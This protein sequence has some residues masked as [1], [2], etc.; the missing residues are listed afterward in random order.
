[1][2]KFTF[3]WR[4]TEKF[5]L[6]SQWY[7]RD[8]VDESGNKYNCSEQF[9]MAMKAQLFCDEETL[10]KIR[11]EKSPRNQKKLG[12]SV[13]GFSESEWN[14]VARK[15]VYAGNKYKF[16]QNP[17]LLKTLLETAGTTLV[18]ASP[19]DKVWGI[20]LKENDPRA[21]DRATWE[22]SNWLGEVLTSLRKDLK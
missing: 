2:E 16:E 4:E 21:L 8:F 17:D 13:K 14:K 11:A 20:G 15:V 9:M 6:F 5:G 12:R 10:I 18:E 7:L 22:G 1:M 19:Y 3:F